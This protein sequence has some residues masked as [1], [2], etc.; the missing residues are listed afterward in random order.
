MR[1]TWHLVPFSSE[2]LEVAINDI[3]SIYFNVKFTSNRSFKIDTNFAEKFCA[4]GLTFTGN[5]LRR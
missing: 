5:Y 3:Q 4:A 2:I 1:D